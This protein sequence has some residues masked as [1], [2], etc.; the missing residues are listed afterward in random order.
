MYL[1]RA[2][3]N[4]SGL[5]GERVPGSTG[6]WVNG[7]KVAAV[8]VRARRWITYHGVALN[9]TTDMAPFQHIVPCGIAD[10]GVSNVKQL[11]EHIV[12]DHEL[13]QEYEYALVDAFAEVFD[14]SVEV[15]YL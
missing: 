7:L 9:V 13:L 15:E 4:V 8:G 5:H 6:V 10:R 2:L 3:E 14:L 12:A 11:C 1:R